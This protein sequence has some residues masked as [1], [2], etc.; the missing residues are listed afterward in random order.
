MELPFTDPTLTWCLRRGTGAP[1]AA[2]MGKRSRVSLEWDP[3]A[4]SR[5]VAGE[6]VRSSRAF[7]AMGKLYPQCI[8]VILLLVTSRGQLDHFRA[9]KL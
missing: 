1:V 2:V 9:G 6:V 3:P 4:G 8:P 5:W 7:E